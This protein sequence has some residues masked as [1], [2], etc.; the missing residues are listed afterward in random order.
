MAKGLKTTGRNEC[1]I[2]KAFRRGKVLPAP[3]ATPEL[4]LITESIFIVLGN[5]LTDPSL[6]RWCLRAY[7]CFRPSHEAH[8]LRQRY[9]SKSFGIGV[10]IP[11]PL[12]RLRPYY[13]FPRGRCPATTR[14]STPPLRPS[15]LLWIA[16]TRPLQTAAQVRSYIFQ[17]SIYRQAEES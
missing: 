10:G 12:I 7:R 6:T 5:G 16:S 13:G 4:L 2:A 1:P 17:F 14:M 3:S 15:V 9:R 8:S 11:A